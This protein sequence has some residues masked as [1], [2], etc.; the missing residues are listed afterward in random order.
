MVFSLD[1]LQTC[2]NETNEDRSVM[3]YCKDAYDTLMRSYSS[4]N[5]DTLPPR[6]MFHFGDSYSIKNG[7]SLPAISKARPVLSI[8]TLHSQPIVW[9]LNMHRHYSQVNNYHDQKVGGKE[10]AWKDKSSTVFWRGKPTGARVP[11]LSRFIHYDRSVIDVAF[12]GVLPNSRG[13]RR[14]FLENHHIRGG[15]NV[16]DM[17]HYKY[18]LSVEGNDVA[19]GLK[20]MLYS[21]SVVFMPL[22]KF[23]TWAMEDLLLPFVHYV[24]LADDLS[25]MLEMIQW[26]EQHEKACQEISKRATEFMEHLWLDEQAQID[27]AHLKQKLATAY[28]DQFQESLSQCDEHHQRKD[29]VQMVFGQKQNA[30]IHTLHP[31]EVAQYKFP[32][33]EERFEY[34]M[35]DWY[36]Q[37]D[38]KVSSCDLLVEGESQKSNGKFFDHDM[39]FSLDTLQTCSNETN[40]DRSVMMYCKDAYDTLMRSYSSDNP[41]TLPPRA[42]FHFGDS[43]SIKNGQSLPAISKARPVLSIN[44]LHSQPIVWPLNM[45]RH[46]SQVNNYHD[47]KVGGKEVAWKDKSSTVFWRGKPTGA[48]VP[49]LSRFIHYDRSVI[50]VAFHGVLPNS[51]GFR[52]TFLENHHI[53]GGVNVTDMSHYK[54]LLSVEGNDVA[55]GLK[56]M[57]YSN[58]VVFMPLPKFATWAMEDLLLPFV[59]Y[60]PLADDLSNMLEMIQWAEQHEKACQEISKRATEFME[61][62]WLDEQA[63]ID[64]AHLKQKLATAYVDQFQE[65]LS[66]CDEHHQRNA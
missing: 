58:S 63:Q 49:L 5:P 4:D 18:L 8:N 21:N 42:M 55:S 12:H 40:E 3:M 46:Y 2:S 59:H 61:H 33:V 53:R 41:D 15:V 37:T 51:R 32:S 29:S 48:R 50:D 26:A 39:V 52:R 27:N 11:L 66:Q 30:G 20:W 38:W 34:Y 64:N 17:S 43:Y 31:F 10:V 54:Y 9:P 28:V 35:G 6:A 7:Q 44:T 60:V 25:N 19:S 47:Q 24:P 22:P 45:H 36:N 14:T 1:T 56:W 16:T 62:L 57:L 65:S 13:F 23:A